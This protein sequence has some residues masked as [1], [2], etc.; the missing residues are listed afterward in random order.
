MSSSLHRALAALAL[1][2]LVLVGLTV[3]L[4]LTSD[5]IEDRGLNAAIVSLL[6]STYIGVGLYAW[7]RRP[8]NRFG[9]IMTAVGFL[10]FSAALCAS[11]SAL[12]F[13][14][15]IA[16]SS[17]YLVAAIH[18]L[19]AFPTGRIPTR[20]QRWLIGSAYVVAVVAPL[21]MMMFDRDGSFDEPIPGNAFFVADAP[22]LLSVLDIAGPL[23]G[24]AIIKAI[25][26]ILVQRWRRAAPHERP[27][28]S[29]LLWTG[30]TMIGLLATLLTVE[31][32]ASDSRIAD[33]VTWGA[34]AMFAALP[35]AF[36]AGLRRSRV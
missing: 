23:I 35:F 3:A 32:V 15:G 4:S 19:L 18:M 27:A 30:S 10:A 11:N 1:I 2:G 28:L 16:S 25:S 24:V 5:H 26:I 8:Q 20:A 29:P 6:M 7:W 9:A 36:L 22:G 14:I 31:L 21:T 17:L 34:L 13:C 33:V 12:I